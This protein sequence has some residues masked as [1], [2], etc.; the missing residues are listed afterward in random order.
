MISG[1][2]DLTQLVH[3]VME[4]KGKSGMVKGLFIPITANDLFE[5]K[6]GNVYL[7]IIAFDADKPEYKQTHAL[8]QSFAKDRYTKEELSAKPFLGHLNAKMGAPSEQAPNNASKGI[9]LSEE[10]EADLPF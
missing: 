10:D 6:N 9:V 3:V 2:I 7:D 8:K 1:K 5:G 4:K